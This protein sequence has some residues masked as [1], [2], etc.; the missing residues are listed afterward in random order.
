MNPTVI[1]YYIFASSL[2]LSRGVAVLSSR[3]PILPE[4]HGKGRAYSSP[5]LFCALNVTYYLLL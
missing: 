3:E 4:G 1:P 2:S 5:F